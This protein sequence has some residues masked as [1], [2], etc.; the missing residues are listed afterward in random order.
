MVCALLPFRT[1]IN[2]ENQTD[3]SV[4]KTESWEADMILDNCLIK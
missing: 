2:K 4:S 3:S 1:K